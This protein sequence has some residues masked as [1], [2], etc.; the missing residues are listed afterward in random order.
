MGTALFYL[1]V[2]WGLFRLFKKKKKTP[3]PSLADSNLLAL[4][5]PSDFGLKIN[6]SGGYSGGSIRERITKTDAKWVLP[7]EAV[8]IGGQV[9]SSG[10]IYVGSSLSADAGGNNYSASHEQDPALINPKL[11]IAKA[12]PDLEGKHMGY[13]PSYSDIM[14]VCRLAYLQWLA[15][16]KCAPNISIG[17]VFLY[18]YGLER[19]IIYDGVSSEEINS[20]I[21]EIERLRGIY[22]KNRSFEGYSER[23]LDVARFILAARNSDKSAT[24]AKFASMLPRLESDSESSR[25]I[26]LAGL[27]AQLQRSSTLS[28]EWAM[29]G[30]FYAAGAYP[31][32]AARRVRPVFIELMRKRFEKKWPQGFTTRARKG[33]SRHLVFS[34]NG[35]SRFIYV[36][37]LLKHLRLG[38]L[39]DPETYIWTPLVGMAAKA[40][41]DLAAYARAVGRQPELMDGPAAITLLP[42][43][44]ANERL[45]KIN[46]SLK[47]WLAQIATPVGR[48]TLKELAERILPNVP[49]TLD[50]RKLET[51]AQ[52]LAYADY[53]FEPDPLFGRANLKKEMAVVFDAG[54]IKNIRTAPSEGYALAKAIAMLMAGIAGASETGLGEAEIRWLG[55]IQKTV[56]LPDIEY[57]R[58]RAHL[59]WLTMQNLTMA[60]VKRVLSSIPEHQRDTVARFA[61]TVAAADGVIEKGEVAF[62]EKIYDELG[63]ERG[64][65]YA[66][67]H[68][69]AA[70]QAQPAA[71]PV[72]VEKPSGGSQKRYKIQP[73]PDLRDG[74]AK[75]TLS[76]DRINKILKETEQVSNILVGVFGDAQETETTAAKPI[77]EPADS[78][79]AG[80]DKAHAAL[81]AFL[82]G[83]NEW[84][85]TDF[86]SK[87]RALGLMPDGALET[88]ND[89]AF[90][91]FEEPLI[92]DGDVME[93]NY[94]LVA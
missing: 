39:P 62:L 26:Q 30:Y 32:I 76:Q 14:P 73:A 52:L 31:K 1:L 56:N 71:E 43:E 9:I 88:I 16:G 87:A 75:R 24:L 12:D 90:D 68:E 33:S 29:I 61:A 92:E 64:K 42:P 4:P 85:R 11:Q 65:L 5:A 34:F 70:E 69:M 40:E 57:R 50:Q 77:E 84:K 15:G 78:R 54:G 21:G 86:E 80:L 67:L 20:L 44:L 13:W 27:A 19:R 25:M 45:D 63:I 74:S 35:S 82:A 91:H 66:T 3:K 37:D 41:E 38:S 72:T 46:E 10:Y 55:W 6:V 22:S 47:P 23:L 59:E 81:V 18:L 49:A 7:G 36:P 94:A 89:W 53:G 93:V 51:I 28:F 79:F 58:L 17:Y 83:Q 48:V 2:A 60:Q 8:T